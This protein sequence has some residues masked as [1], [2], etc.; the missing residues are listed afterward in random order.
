MIESDCCNCLVII[1][2]YC[3]TLARKNN[4]RKGKVNVAFRDD[5]DDNFGDGDILTCFENRL[6]K[7]L[8]DFDDIDMSDGELEIDDDSLPG[9]ISVSRDDA[10]DFIPDCSDAEAAYYKYTISIPETIHN[11][12]SSIP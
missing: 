3:T 4:D 7:C 1:L 8:E 6:P 5:Y 2:P 11:Y 12:N 10:P 9:L